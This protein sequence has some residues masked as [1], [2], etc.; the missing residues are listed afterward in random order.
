MTGHLRPDHW[1]DPCPRC[2]PC[3]ECDQ[4]RAQ[5]DALG[6]LVAELRSELEHTRGA[7]ARTQQVVVTGHGRT[8]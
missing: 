2:L 6:N 1:R 7:L 3:H 4:L 8:T 5:V